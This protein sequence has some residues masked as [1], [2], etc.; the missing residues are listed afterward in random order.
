MQIFPRLLF[1]LFCLM[2]LQAS[3]SAAVNLMPYPQQISVEDGLL[4][5]GDTL[6]YS[7][8][9]FDSPRLQQALARFSERIERQTGLP[10][11]LKKSSRTKN[12]VHLTI[13]VASDAAEEK[14]STI[15]TD[16]SYQLRITTEQIHLHAE[17]TLGALHA[18][19]TLLQ[20]PVPWGDSHAYPLV[21]ITDSPRFPWRGAL[22]DV[23]RHFLSIATLKRQIDAM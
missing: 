2:P 4:I 14:F 6:T 5:M 21:S 17:T 8:E 9:S 13:D 7:V 18:L 12:N 22:I 3:A 10:L 23:S 11:R 19:E 20:L 16:E 1:L 15:G